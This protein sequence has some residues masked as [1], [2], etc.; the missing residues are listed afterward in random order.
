MIPAPL[1]LEASE[2]DLNYGSM[3]VHDAILRR[4][5]LLLS[6]YDPSQ[7]TDLEV[8]S[9][10]HPIPAEPV[11]A[12]AT[13]NLTNAECF[14][15]PTTS[16]I[17]LNKPILNNHTRSVKLVRTGK[18]LSYTLSIVP[19]CIVQSLLDAKTI[20]SNGV[21]NGPDVAGKNCVPDDFEYQQ[22]TDIP[23]FVFNSLRNYLTCELDYLIDLY[24]T[25]LGIYYENFKVSVPN[26]SHNTTQ[27]YLW[28][29]L[30]IFG[31]NQLTASYF[32]KRI[33]VSNVF[34]TKDDAI[35]LTLKRLAHDVTI[36]L[37]DADDVTFTLSLDYEAVLKLL[38]PLINAYFIR[39]LS[40]KTLGSH[41]CIS[42]FQ[43]DTTTFSANFVL[44]LPTNEPTIKV[45]LPAECNLT[46]TI[47]QSFKA[48]EAPGHTSDHTTTYKFEIWTPIEPGKPEVVDHSNL[49]LSHQRQ[50]ITSITLTCGLAESE[51][52]NEILKDSLASNKVK[53][54]DVIML[55]INNT[56]AGSYWVAV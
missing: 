43:V 15:N 34:A 17:N 49:Q 7:L 1:D 11:F 23:T 3:T 52:V 4:A 5:E 38:Q 56:G 10:P 37:K 35:V 26:L 8:F 27:P 20:D 53:P 36:T 40:N 28:A 16:Y 22:V 39:K 18:M 31:D 46:S 25:G 44:T 55:L 32:A 29:G 9:L 48:I 14:T 12:W 33:G 21:F 6:G 51:V 24:S 42:N 41:S 13:A 47:R 50:D 19:D 2:V 30:S 54:G 45:N